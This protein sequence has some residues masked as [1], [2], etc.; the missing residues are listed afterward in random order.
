MTVTIER[1][2]ADERMHRDHPQHPW[3]TR[4]RVR[5]GASS[6]VEYGYWWCPGWPRQPRPGVAALSE[7]PCGFRGTI[8]SSTFVCTRTEHYSDTTRGY[9]GSGHV[10]VGVSRTTG[11]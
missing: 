2:C 8:G 5:A 10:M 3:E 9:F 1:A 7:K 4:P 6:R 11:G